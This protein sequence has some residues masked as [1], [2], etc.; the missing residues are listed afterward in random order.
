MQV[1]THL[2]QNLEILGLIHLHHHPK[3]LDI[4]Y[5]TDKAKDLGINPEELHKKYAPL[6][7]R[8]IT[9]FEKNIVLEDGDGLFFQDEESS[10]LIFLQIAFAEIPEWVDGI[11][12]ISENDVRASLLEGMSEWLAT[13][14]KQ[15]ATLQEI[16]EILKA[17]ALP[18]N[19]CWK[20]M[21][22]LQDPKQHI[23][24]LVEII[25]RNIPSYQK[26]IQAIE[27]PLNRQLEK[28]IK[29]H[30]RRVERKAR[31]RIVEI[32]GKLS[33]LPTPRTIIPTLVQ[34]SME[35]ILTE[36][37]YVGL[38]IDDLY[39]MLENLQKAKGASNPVLKALS[40]S[41]K[42]DI[43]LSLHNAPKYNLELAEHL[44]LTAATITHH[45]QSL[46]LHGLVSVEKRDGR[47]YYT[48]QKDGIRAAVAQLQEIFS[49]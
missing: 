48:L 28:F 39:Q 16:V 30:Q 43:L 26:A 1:H 5:Y 21:L 36:S 2:N 6:L 37:N 10:V 49:I 18:S 19:D 24:R 31:Q 3:L 40:D 34:P 35:V 8:Y 15:D 42:F 14:I 7:K 38:F 25:R 23:Q 13:D 46:L 44:G 4:S 41:S 32:A 22:L 47:V 45:M 33:P 29:L 12:A 20:V 17:S 11:E 27:K 9:E